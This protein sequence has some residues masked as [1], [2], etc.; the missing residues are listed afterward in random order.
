MVKKK[1]VGNKKTDEK[2]I[3]RLIGD[4]GDPA[5]GERHNAVEGL[6]KVGEPAVSPLIR[7]LEEATNND[8]RWYA[9]VALGAIGV[10]S[11]EPLLAALRGNKDTNFRRYGAAAL[12]SMG[13]PAVEPLISAIGQRRPRPAGLYLPGPLSYR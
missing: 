13:A 8:T 12:G 5:I 10:P 11:I 7:M 6:R 2:E 4:L 9:A 3:S 1:S